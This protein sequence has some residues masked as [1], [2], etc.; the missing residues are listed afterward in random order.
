MTNSS[1]AL[2]VVIPT[3]NNVAV[4]VQC[5]ASW[6]TFAPRESFE[7]VIIED[8]CNDGTSDYLQALAQSGWGRRHLRWHHQTNVHE[9]RCT[10]H[11]LRDARAPLI[12]AWQDDMFLRRRW[13]V[14]EL[15]AT[16]GKYRELGL[17]CLSRGLNCLPLDEPIA[18]CEDL[19]DMHQVLGE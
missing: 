14:P 12:M 11:G 1:P 8:G 3:F 7:L 6:H 4:L 19:I 15:L 2:S 16:F 17:L 5:L 9:L 13:L 10:N 18:S